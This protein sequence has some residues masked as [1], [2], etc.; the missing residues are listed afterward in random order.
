MDLVGLSHI[1]L[2]NN[3]YRSSV[4]LAMILDGLFICSLIVVLFLC[5][6]LLRDYVEQNSMIDEFGAPPVRVAPAD[7][8]IATDAAM[9]E[10]DAV[11]IPP[12]P[13]P[14]DAVAIEPARQQVPVEPAVEVQQANADVANPAV[15]NNQNGGLNFGRNMDAIAQDD[16]S[17]EVLFGLRGPVLHIFENLFWVVLFNAVFIGALVFIPFNIGKLVLMVCWSPYQLPAFLT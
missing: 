10:G 12:G 14:E 3:F 9:A 8:G 11:A 7:A 1:C 5:M 15:P 17:F 6:M 4:W 16:V 13:E 2:T